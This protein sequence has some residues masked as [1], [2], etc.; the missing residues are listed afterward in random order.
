MR[1]ADTIAE[2]LLA[3][4]MALPSAGCALVLAARLAALGS[5]GFSPAALAAVAMP[6]IV[7]DADVERLAALEALDL[8]ELGRLRFLHYGGEAD[9]YSRRGEW[10]ALTPRG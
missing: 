9:L 5:P 6:A 1:H 7:R 3:P 4:A 2:V 10:E 8:D